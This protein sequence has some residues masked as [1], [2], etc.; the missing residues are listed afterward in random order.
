[1]TQGFV[2]VVD[3][4]DQLEKLRAE[5]ATISLAAFADVEAGMVLSYSA[6]AKPAQETLDRLC[7]EAQGFLSSD[8]QRS[9]QSV[10]EQ[11]ETGFGLAW[12]GAQLHL[13][14]GSEN[15]PSEALL[16]VMAAP[17]DPMPALAAARAV[18]AG[19]GQGA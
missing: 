7:G 4:R 11:A 8:A 2:R 15:D 3:I 1:M 5:N 12:H 16:L 6:A 9:M 18:L 10:A 17:C 13:F 14:L 19:I